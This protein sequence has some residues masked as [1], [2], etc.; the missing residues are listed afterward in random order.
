MLIASVNTAQPTRIHFNGKA[1]TTG[2]FK[3]PVAGCATVSAEGIAGDTIVDTKVH[4]GLDL[5]I[6]APRTPCFKLGV[7]MN[8]AGFVQA[9]AKANRPGAYARV[10]QGGTLSAGD[11]VRVVKTT[12]DYAPVKAVFAEWHS[13]EKSPARL[14]Q[15]LASPIARVHKKKI[16]AWYEQLTAD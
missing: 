5:E 6:T 8:D 4:G 16:Q 7:R 3:T 10:I 13:K 14:R 11:P 9:F 2:L 15:A 1:V 12:K